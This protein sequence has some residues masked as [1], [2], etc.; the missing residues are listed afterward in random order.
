M[1]TNTPNPSAVAAI[2]QLDGALADFRALHELLRALAA[3]PN[4]LESRALRPIVQVLG[5]AV[6]AAEEG[7]ATLHRQPTG[8]HGASEE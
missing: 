4:L 7:W 1:G 2:D 8:E 5:D 6:D 3:N